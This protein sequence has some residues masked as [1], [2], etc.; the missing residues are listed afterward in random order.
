MK[1]VVVTSRTARKI[2]E[3]LVAR[4]G[5]VRE[6]KLQ[7]EV[8]A[9]PVPVIGIFDAPTLT[10][11]LERH[12]DRLAGSDLVLV[13][14][15][16]PGDFSEASR[17][18]GVPVAKASRDAGLLP[19]VLDY[20]AEGGTA[21]PDKPAEEYLAVEASVEARIAF[22]AH[23]LR[24]PVRGPPMLLAAEVPPGAM[25]STGLARRY[26]D[27]GADLIVIGYGGLDYSQ[28]LVS[29]LAEE[30]VPAYAEAPGPREAQRLVDSGAIGLVVGPETAMELAGR[31]PRDI[32]IVVGDRSLEPLAKAVS[33]LRDKGHEAVFVDPVVGVPLVDMA[34]TSLRYWSARALGVPLWFSAANVATNLYTDTH[35]VYVILAVWAAELGASTFLVVEDGYHT[36]HSVAEARRA[37]EMVEAAW[38]L[39]RPPA[40]PGVP[41]AFTIKQPDPPPPPHLSPEGAVLVE[42]PIEPRLDPGYFVVSVDHD[43]RLIIVEYREAGRTRKWAGA[44]ARHLARAVLRDVAVSRE[45]AAYLGI[46]LYKAELALRLG[47]TYV[48]D[49]EVLRPLWE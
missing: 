47:K 4:S 33:R 28:P 48:Q 43:R 20:I 36:I 38:A 18:L 27:E 19:R 15:G 13:P 44:N 49:Q 11:L 35:S 23:G 22:E 7:V 12:R 40:G 6:G 34:A 24:V 21:R 45:H 25:D 31:I 9:L 17:R 37:L 10:R 41:W 5:A 42:E 16:I 14:G 30:G 1:V 29:M 8:L 26:L 2:I 39:R 3:E 46:E 32:A